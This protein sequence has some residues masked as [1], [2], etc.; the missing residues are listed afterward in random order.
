M[1]N[2]LDVSGG[3]PYNAENGYTNG[4]MVFGTRQPINDIY[5]TDA[6]KNA[7]PYCMYQVSLK[8][9]RLLLQKRICKL[10]LACWTICMAMKAVC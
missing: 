6:Q 2:L 1:G 9:K 8:Y 4:R 5:V 7:T 10:C 3:E